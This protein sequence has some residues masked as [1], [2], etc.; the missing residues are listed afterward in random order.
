MNR[1]LL[2]AAA[3]VV[4]GWPALAQPEYGHGDNMPAAGAISSAPQ[5]SQRSV[6]SDAEG[7]AEDLRLNGKCDQAVPILRSLA[8]G[9]GY[10]ISR[11]HLGLCLITL[12]DAEHDASRAVQTRHEGATWILRA[13]NAGFAQA[14]AEAVTLRL[15]GVGV[16]NDP[17]EAEKW[18]LIYRHNSMRSVL[19]LP[20]IAADVSDRLDAALTNATRAQAEARADAWS[21]TAS[22]D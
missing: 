3:A 16:E 14:E 19:N 6:N 11:Y 8:E 18:A 15:N 9:T 7:R 2:I 17:V 10:P 4:L 13:A 20:D 21:P 5:Q 22:S 12:A 1:I